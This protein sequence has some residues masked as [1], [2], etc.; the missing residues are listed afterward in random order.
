MLNEGVAHSMGVG[1][2]ECVEGINGS[3]AGAAA[4]HRGVESGNVL[5]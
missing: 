2:E 1:H 5:Q 4:V 3:I